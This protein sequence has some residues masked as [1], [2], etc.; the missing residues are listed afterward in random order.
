MTASFEHRPVRQSKTRRRSSL[1]ARLLENHR[2]SSALSDVERNHFAIFHGEV[3]FDRKLGMLEGPR[4]NGV[5]HGRL[6]SWWAAGEFSIGDLKFQLHALRG[7]TTGVALE[8]LG[9]HLEVGLRRRF[10]ARF[11]QQVCDLGFVILHG[12]REGAGKRFGRDRALM[13]EHRLHHL[14]VAFFYSAHEYIVGAGGGALRQQELDDLDALLFRGP[15]ERGGPVECVLH[16][17]VGAVIEQDLDHFDIAAIR[18]EEQAGSAVRAFGVDVGALGEQR[19][20]AVGVTLANSGQ[21]IFAEIGEA[22]KRNTDGEK[23]TGYSSAH[24]RLLKANYR[25]LYLE[26]G[27]ECRASTGAANLRGRHRKPIFRRPWRAPD[28]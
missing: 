2:I 22:T 7:V 14:G 4:S 27:A 6:L 8:R 19:L 5:V 9:I 20:H 16:V 26:D 18:R 11:P 28:I 15:G 1:G 12:R 10:D 21:K 17:Y 24:A 3:E 13:F 23:Q 25:R